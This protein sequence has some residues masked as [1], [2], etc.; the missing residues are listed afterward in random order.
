MDQNESKES[1]KIKNYLSKIPEKFHKNLDEPID[2]EIVCKVA[3]SMKQDWIANYD[4]LELSFN[5]LKD[6]QQENNLAKF[7]R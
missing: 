1:E 7:Q 5:K 6:I 3:E 2:E 4:I